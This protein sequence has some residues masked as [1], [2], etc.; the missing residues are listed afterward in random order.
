ML[1]VAES[2]A[3]GTPVITANYGSTQEIAAAGGAITID[4]RDD[5]ALISAMRRLLTDDAL[6]EQL[7]AQL[8]DGLA[9]RLGVRGM[10]SGG[11]LVEHIDDAEQIGT[12]LGCQ[13]Q[14]LQFARRKRR[15]APLQR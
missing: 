8:G 13:S 1:N 15:G 6:L 10:K 9:K 3:A 7:R 12:H 2:L 11:G 14:A 4:P 5:E